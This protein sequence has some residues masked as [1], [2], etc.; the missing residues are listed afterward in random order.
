M[1]AAGRK[2]LPCL[3]NK[4]R[5]RE[6]LGLRKGKPTTLLWL[7]GRAVRGT[8]AMPKPASTMPSKVPI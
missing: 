4:P 3:R 8:A 2:L 1:A 5:R 6:I 7:V